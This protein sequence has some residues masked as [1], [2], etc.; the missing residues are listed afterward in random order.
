MKEGLMNFTDT[1]LTS[2]GLMIFFVFFV[3]VVIWTNLKSQ[4]DLYLKM[5]KMPLEGENHE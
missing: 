4:K 2:V 1:Y 3:T 5:E